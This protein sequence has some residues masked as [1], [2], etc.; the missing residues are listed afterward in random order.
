MQYKSC[1]IAGLKVETPLDSVSFL[2]DMDNI[3]KT[4]FCATSVDDC[5]K[6]ESKMHSG[7]YCILENLKMGYIFRR[8]CDFLQIAENTRSK[9][10]IYIYI[11]II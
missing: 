4:T 5:I 2:N 7:F 11:Y 9:K 10:N 6:P 1:Y 8:V 3:L